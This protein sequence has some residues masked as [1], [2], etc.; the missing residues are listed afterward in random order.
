MNIT[1]GR[2]FLEKLSSKRKGYRPISAVTLQEKSATTYS[3]S[4]L[5]NK[6]MNGSKH[7]HH[8]MESKNHPIMSGM[9]TSLL[10]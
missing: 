1:L 2:Y 6:N 5:C 9:K 10:T 8:K 7:V 4:K 3:A